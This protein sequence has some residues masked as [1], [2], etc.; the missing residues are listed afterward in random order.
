MVVVLEVG[1][2]ESA[3]AYPFAMMRGAAT[4]TVIP[5][6]FQRLPSRGSKAE[7]TVRGSE[8]GRKFVEILFEFLFVYFR[9]DT[10]LS[11]GFQ[12]HFKHCCAIGQFFC[13]FGGEPHFYRCVFVKLYRAEVLTGSVV[14]IQV[15][16]LHYLFQQG[17]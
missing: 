7:R 4:V 9:A 15:Q 13:L 2:T 11:S 6:P 8:Q 14:D 17:A 16:F 10:Q 3:L 1:S 12:Y 5:V